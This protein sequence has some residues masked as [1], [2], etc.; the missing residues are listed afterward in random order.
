VP[1]LTDA[2]ASRRLATRALRRAGVTSHLRLGAH[3]C[4]H[5]AASQLVNRGARC[6]AVAD[7]LGHRA[8]QTTGIDAKRA[9]DARVAVA[10]PG[11]G[12]TR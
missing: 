6:N 2:T 11:R 3:T 4:R 12:E 5:P 7:V 9:L 10:L 8:L 1:P